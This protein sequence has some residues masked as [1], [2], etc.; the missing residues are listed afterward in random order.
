MT[1]H[2]ATFRRSGATVLRSGWKS[3]FLHLN[4]S[5]PIF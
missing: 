4:L 1:K 3:L 5:P 2:H